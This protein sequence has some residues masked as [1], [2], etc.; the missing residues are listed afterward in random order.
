MIGYEYLCLE[1]DKFEVKAIFGDAPLTAHCPFCAIPCKRV[2][3]V[4]QIRFVGTGWTVKD[5]SH[6]FEQTFP[7]LDRA[8]R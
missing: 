2:F 3:S 1:H 6:E 7:T 5:K 4:P 8:S